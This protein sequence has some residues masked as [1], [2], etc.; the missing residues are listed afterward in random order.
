MPERAM[1]RPFRKHVAIAI[2]GGGIRGIIPVL[3]LSMLEKE[4][5]KPA[6][7]IFTLA[8]GTSTGSIISAGIGAGVSAEQMYNLYI[9]LG[10]SIFANTLRKKVFPLTRYRYS[11]GPLMEALHSYFGDRCM[12]DFW[13]QEN[14]IDVIIT[15]FDLV[16]NNTRFIKPWK[17]QYAAWPVVNAVRASSTVPTFFPV[18]EGRYVD[19]GVG[20]YANPSYLAAYEAQFIL[21]WDPNETTLISLGTGRE[22]YR[23]EPDGAEQLWAWQW[24][25]PMFGAFL[26]SADD[27]QLHLVD[28]FFK[29]IDFRRYQVDLPQPIEMDDISK[30]KLLSQQGERMGRMLLSD[31]TDPAQYILAK[32]PV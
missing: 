27:Q 1:M 24:L 7:E 16:D 23:Y 11:A 10:P 9:E 15:T 12:A 32:R 5:G 30:M 31:M 22:P 29:A 21:E 6:G 25:K 17:E 18:F 19:G 26:Q 28:T 20:A 8:A 4:L 3:A 14:R 13:S 2:D